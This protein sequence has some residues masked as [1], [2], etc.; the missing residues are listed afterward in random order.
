MDA[1]EV[2]VWMLGVTLAVFLILSIVL[3]AYLIKIALQIK[4]ITT[5]AEKAAFKF[6][7]IMGV[8]QKAAAPAIV[9]KLA[10]DLIMKFV[11]KRRKE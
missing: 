5:T 9:T 1:T 4:R 8:M 3:V 7:S 11:N 2:L 6:D 10:N